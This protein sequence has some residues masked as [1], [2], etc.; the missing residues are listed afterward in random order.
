VGSDIVITKKL[1]FIFLIFISITLVEGCWNY[2]EI[3]QLDPVVGL[4]IDKDKKNSELVLTAEIIIPA[5]S[6]SKSEFKSLI[7]ESR[8]GTMFEAMRQL[9][10]KTGRSVYWSH[11]NIII[12]SK[13]IAEEGINEV[14]D[15]L[16][17]DAEIRGSL[18]VLVS[19]EKTAKEI[20]E[21][22]HVQDV[23]RS[24]HLTYALKNQERV[25]KYPKVKLTEVAE[26]LANNDSVLLLTNVE[27]KSY[28]DRIQ[29]EVSGSAILKYD[30]VVGYLD[31]EATQ[32]ALWARGD[33]KGGI[34]VVRDILDSGNNI[35]FE[36]FTSKTKFKPEYTEN[37]IYMKV[38]I[39]TLVSISEVSGNIAFHEEETKKKLEEYAEKALEKQLK[40]II[41]KAQTEYNSDIFKFGNKIRVDNPKLWNNIKDNW[42]SEFS[43]VIVDVSVDL[44]IK[45]SSLIGRPIK[46]GDK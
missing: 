45:G 40:Y 35:S 33:L 37:S 28:P 27:I 4:A 21:S 15:M 10:I 6:E 12:L 13:D 14:F 41:K 36:V 34:L 31:A 23:I 20:F 5:T 3:E 18:F 8:G 7:Y 26:N 43:D 39:S 24:D 17:R 32:Y 38:D 25:S 29:P 1:L 42:S 16:Y 2:R 19:K 44:N 11:M 30:K 22:G 9:I 46:G